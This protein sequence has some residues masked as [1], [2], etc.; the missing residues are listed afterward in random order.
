M[1]CPDI[2]KSLHVFLDGEFAEAERVEVQCH[3]HACPRCAGRVENERRLMH[4]VREGAPRAAMP[5]D[6]ALRLRALLAA[7]PSP[8][9]PAPRAPR[10]RAPMAWVTA[11]ALAATAVIAAIWLVAAGRDPAQRVA[12]EAIASHARTPPLEVRGSSQ[13]VRQ[14]LAANVPF[15]VDIPFSGDEG[16]ELVGARLTR[17]DGRDAVLL[18][19][20]AGDEPLTVV[21]VAAHPAERAGD[22]GAGAEPRVY[23]ENGYDAVLL[24]RKGVLSSFV[25]SGRD[26]RLPRLVR[27]A[28][29]P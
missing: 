5:E 3:L 13:H 24:E 17:V 22:A 23:S 10:Q 21:Q 12:T 6:A 15:E 16:I 2:D 19:F 9:A 1:N 8:V 29:R 28:W 11:A 25:G 14:Y 18:H 27:A 4:A 20:R 26:G 7:T